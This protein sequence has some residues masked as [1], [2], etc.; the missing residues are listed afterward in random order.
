MFEPWYL[1]AVCILIN[2]IFPFDFEVLFSDVD[3]MA[4]KVTYQTP[5]KLEDKYIQDPVHVT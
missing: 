4:Y 2:G 5:N 3:F 1:K